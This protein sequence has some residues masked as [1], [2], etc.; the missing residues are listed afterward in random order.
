MKSLTDKHSYLIHFLASLPPKSRA[1]LIIELTPC[2]IRTISEIFKNFLNN[3]LTQDKKIIRKV[4]KY[5]NEINK[6]ALKKT[7]IY[8]K[9]KI[10][11]NKKGGFILA[12]LIPL[13][14]SL[15]SSLFK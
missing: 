5:K 9:K 10:L 4:R 12:T 13:A 8:E 14:A 11:S 6:V 7:P 3:N 15:I 1:R 2:H